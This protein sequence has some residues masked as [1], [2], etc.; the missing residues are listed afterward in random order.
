M[1][2]LINTVIIPTPRGDVLMDIVPGGFFAVSRRDDEHRVFG[3]DIAAAFAH[4]N[5]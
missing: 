1:N 2:H 3:R 5:S 4:A